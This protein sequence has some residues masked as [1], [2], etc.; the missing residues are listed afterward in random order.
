M[1]NDIGLLL[2]LRGE[3]VCVQALEGGYPTVEIK[4]NGNGDTSEIPQSTM[5]LVVHV[6]HLTKGSPPATTIEECL[7]EFIRCR[8]VL[9]WITI[10]RVNRVAPL[11]IR[12]VAWLGQL[13]HPLRVP[14]IASIRICR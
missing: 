12:I 14:N 9:D 11:N 6:A 7:A 3:A 5:I 2:R 10:R 1:I 13:D 8:V 4:I